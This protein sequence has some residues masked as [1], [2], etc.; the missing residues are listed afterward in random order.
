LQNE[1]LAG[2]LRIVFEANT[3]PR[4]IAEFIEILSTLYSEDL[5]I[6]TMDTLP[7]DT[8]EE[9]RKAA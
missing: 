8:E 6:L 9:V 5:N 7:P 4:R 1:Q 3:S 2:P